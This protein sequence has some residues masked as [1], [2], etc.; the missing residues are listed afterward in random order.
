MGKV[1][2]VREVVT[3]KLPPPP[4]RN[5]QNRS[6]FSAAEAVTACP[7]GKTTVADVNVSESR[8]ACRD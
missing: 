8:P 2:N 1:A 3:P 4:P 6:G 5:A 7:L